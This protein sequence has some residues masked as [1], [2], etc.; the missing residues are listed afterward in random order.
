MNAFTPYYRVY[1]NQTKIIVISKRDF[2]STDSSFLYRISKGIIRFQYD[3]PEYHD[4]TT[5]P[6][7]MQKAKEGAL[8][9]IQSLILEGQK[10]VSAL[11]KYRYDHYID[12]NYHL[13]DAEIQKLERQLKNK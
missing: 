10:I 4:Y 13:L 2:T 5:L 7:A 3:T 9:F 8:L 11:K 12:L 1:N 6:L